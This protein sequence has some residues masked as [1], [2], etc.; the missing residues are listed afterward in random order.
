MRA[1]VII[2]SA[3]FISFSGQ[4]DDTGNL[5]KMA[6]KKHIIASQDSRKEKTATAKDTV[7]VMNA[8]IVELPVQIEGHLIITLGDSAL[9]FLQ[10]K[11]SLHAIQ[12]N[13]IRVNKGNIVIPLNDYVVSQGT[14]GANFSFV[15]GK[16]YVISY[17][18]S[19]KQY[20]IIQTKVM[21]F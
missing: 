12:I 5:Y 9:S 7:F 15:G 19:T 16:E 21:S 8:E 1:I 13:P 3:V 14:Q 20:T 10:D 4:D 17:N 11:P 18:S 2:L 6:L